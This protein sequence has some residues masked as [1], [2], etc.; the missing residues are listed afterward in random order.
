MN[1]F[2]GTYE[3]DAQGATPEEEFR[4]VGIYQNAFEPLSENGLRK[5]AMLPRRPCYFCQLRPDNAR[6]YNREKEMRRSKQLPEQW[7]IQAG[8]EEFNFK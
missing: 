7:Q 8:S 3:K 6:G 5:E 1:S 4:T 2:T